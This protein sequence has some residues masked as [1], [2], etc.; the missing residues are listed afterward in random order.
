MSRPG[1][2]PST[3]KDGPGTRM[4]P[5]KHQYLGAAPLA[6]A[7]L[8]AA[9]LAACHKTAP[10]PHTA[11][12]L[13]VSI[14]PVRTMVL[15]GAV[16]ASGVLIPKLEAAVSTELSGY[17]V[18]QVLVDQDAQVSAGQPLARLDDTLL[19]AQI[20]QQQALVDEQKVASE[21]SVEEAKR[22]A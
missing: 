12:P 7:I 5:I 19:R 17:R 13:T 15:K 21:R 8:A 10:A 18:A 22:V 4:R 14:T 11:A 6:M 9:A 1:P 20:A 3:H 2:T 16:T